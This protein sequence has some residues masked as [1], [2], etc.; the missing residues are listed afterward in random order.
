MFCSPFVVYEVQLLLHL[1]HVAN[2]G[3]A[4][5]KEKTRKIV[6]FLPYPQKATI[7]AKF[8]T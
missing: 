4:N 5:G 8:F 6:V 3:V 2:A 1:C 7:C